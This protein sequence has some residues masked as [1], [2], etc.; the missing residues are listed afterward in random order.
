[1]LKYYCTSSDTATQRQPL[2]SGQQFSFL[3]NYFDSLME[4]NRRRFMN[5]TL[6][7]IVDLALQLP[8]LCRQPLTLLRKQVI[9]TP[10]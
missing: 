3:I 4:T 9:L 7:R 2:S 8:Q 1:M 10:L 5:S 6:P